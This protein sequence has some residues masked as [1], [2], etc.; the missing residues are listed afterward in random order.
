MPRDHAAA[1]SYEMAVKNGDARAKWRLAR[2]LANGWGT[3]KDPERAITLYRE[4]AS[5]GESPGW[6]YFGLMYATGEGAPKDDARAM[7][8]FTR[9]AETGDEVAMY[10]ISLLL[11]KQTPKNLAKIFEWRKKS[12]ERGYAA[13]Q[14]DTGM[15]YHNGEGAEANYGWA[16]YWYA[17]SAQ[18]GNTYAIDNLKKVLPHRNF[19]AVSGNSANLRDAASADS[20][21]LASLPKGTRVY[22]LGDPAPGWKMVYVESGFRLGYLAVISQ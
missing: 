5:A 8:Y 1:A 12:A 11:N 6:F 18:Q 15:S 13:A 7:D 20:K 19:L 21:V 14:N 16:I 9:A 22:P 3:A 4:A 10:N 17:K 2:L